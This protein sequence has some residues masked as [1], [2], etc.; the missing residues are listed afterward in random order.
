MPYSS[1]DTGC[2]AAPSSCF[3]TTPE[4]EP[5]PAA[6]AIRL[7]SVR[8]IY[9]LYDSLHQQALAVLGLDRWLPWQR[10]KAKTFMALD[11]VEL[12]VRHGERVALV[13]RNGAGK[14]TL[15]KLITG[16]FAP[17]AGSV[18]IDG[19]V[20]ALMQV[21]LGFHHDFTGRENVRSSLLYNGLSGAALDAALAEVLDFAELGPFADQPL[22][23]Y[24]LGM[25]SRLQFAAATAIRPDILVVDEVL[26]AGDAYFSA[27]SAARMRQL[28]GSGCTLLLVSHSAQQVLQ[29]CD[30]A[31]WLERGRVV[32]DG[33]ALRVVRA[34]EEFSHRLEY[35]LKQGG[36]GVLDNDW[37]RTKVLHD[38]LAVPEDSGPSRWQGAT[39]LTIAAVEVVDGAGSPRRL[40]RTG[41][42]ATFRLRVAFG[43]S[44]EFPCRFV[45]VVFTADG[46]VL[47]RHVSDQHTLTGA[48]G[49]DIE[50]AL[51]YDRIPYG[52]GDYVFSAALYKELDLDRLAEASHYDLLSRSFDFSVRARHADDPSLIHP[53]AHWQ[54]GGA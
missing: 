15:L 32:M 4:P 34:Y 8:K 10:G 9:R 18:H 3:S 36:R 40:F 53:D 13:G 26:G 28:T 52:N 11:G 41:E 31:V 46:R 19:T 6:A 12:T 17:T 33:E 29:F 30:R 38:T 44:G 21:G 5:A 7:C 14:T 50:V 39:G 54:V 45:I 48:A 49:E 47:T 43:D 35:E 2:S 37:L 24:S 25:R 1:S 23:T 27:K 42:P 16:N 22:K 20:Q 51:R